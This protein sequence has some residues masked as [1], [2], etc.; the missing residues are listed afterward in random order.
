MVFQAEKSPL[1]RAAHGG[2]AFCE[3]TPVCAVG[4]PTQ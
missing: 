2:A 4:T 1:G 3:L